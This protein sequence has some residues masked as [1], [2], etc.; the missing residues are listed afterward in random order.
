M[1]QAIRQG[2]VDVT[3]AFTTDARITAFHL[4]PMRDDKHFYPPYYAAPII[5]TALLKKHPEVQ[6]ALMPL[7]GKIDNRT[8]QHLNYLVDIKKQTP[9]AVAAN[10]VRHLEKIS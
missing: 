7:L 4:T 6:R 9:A 2:A 3:E 5:R 10:F 8:M 1:Y